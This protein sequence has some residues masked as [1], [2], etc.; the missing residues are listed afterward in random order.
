MYFDFLGYQKGE[1]A[2]PSYVM[3]KFN[4]LV[5]FYGPEIV[6]ACIKD[7]YDKI[8]WAVNNIEFKNYTR[9]VNYIMAILKGNIRQVA[10]K[11]K[12]L[13]EMKKRL[14]VTQEQVEEFK[15]LKVDQSV[16][17]KKAKDMTSI[18]EEIE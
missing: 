15:E 13:K 9:K 14:E 1:P 8:M 11:E 5:N 6:L 10:E 16:H 17:S 18:F 4:E 2:P 12:R 7:N 3:K